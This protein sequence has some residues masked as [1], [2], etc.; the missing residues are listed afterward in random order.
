MKFRTTLVLYWSAVGLSLVLVGWWIVFFFRQGGV[1]VER[2]ER[3]GLHLD[4]AGA[5]AVE[6]AARQ[7]LTMFLFE[8][9]F[10]GVL[11]L[12]GVYFVFRSLKREV[13]LHRQQRD[14]LSAVTHELKSPLASS[15]L[16]L[17]SLL[18]GRVPEE[19]KVR[20]LLHAKQDLDR[21]VDTVERLLEAARI[22][23]GRPTLNVHRMDLSAF[24]RGVVERLARQE[25]DGRLTIDV[26]A[27]GEVPVDGDV[28]AVE[29]IL[30]NLIANAVKYAGES[31]RVHVK[32]SREGDRARLEVRDEGPGM[33]GIR[34]S[35]LFD[36]FQRGGD[37]R[38]KGRP[39]VGLGLFLVSELTQALGGK[40]SARN[41]E[42]GFSVEITLPVAAGGVAG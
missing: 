12:G 7:S 25:G 5:E 21:L 29:T 19:R 16:Y 8:G 41:L 31:P 18:Q 9:T 17:E 3:A 20:Y 2:I 6:H 23:N 10:L 15:R 30:R 24:T 1:L 37:E 26:D 42:P 4:P 13:A 35:K 39:G 27:N 28:A 32:V 22:S 33:Q 36:P 11:L 14:L 38:V 40:V 34:T